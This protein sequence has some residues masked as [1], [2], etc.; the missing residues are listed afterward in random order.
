MYKDLPIPDKPV[1]L[2][3]LRYVKTDGPRPK[4][5]TFLLNAKS[6]LSSLLDNIKLRFDCDTTHICKKF[7]QL[8]DCNYLLYPSSNVSD[9]NPYNTL[10]EFTSFVSDIPFVSRC[11]QSV[12]DL[13]FELRDV[14]QHLVTK[15]SEVRGEGETITMISLLKHIYRDNVDHYKIAC[16]FMSFIVSFP[17]SEAIVES[18]GSAIDKI[19]KDKCSFKEHLD[20]DEIDLIEKLVF[21][22]LNGPPPGA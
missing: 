14:R 3:I 12:K 8:I 15:L 1:G 4:F 19:I 16:K 13:Y 21:I 9:N 20:L 7:Q 17:V 11:S 6:Y 10:E 5:R 22:K 2:K 18:W